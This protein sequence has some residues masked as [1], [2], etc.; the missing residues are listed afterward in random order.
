MRLFQ[1][2]VNT[3]LSLFFAYVHFFLSA[4]YWSEIYYCIFT[5]GHIQIIV[6]V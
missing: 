2:F 6:S 1:L 3:A 5:S 4:H